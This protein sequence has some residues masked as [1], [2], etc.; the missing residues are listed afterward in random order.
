MGVFIK[1]ERDG[2]CS[3]DITCVNTVAWEYIAI[4]ESG[5]QA[6]SNSEARLADVL[7]RKYWSYTH[8]FCLVNG[9]KNLPER[10]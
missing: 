3:A 4:I 1:A 10:L 2:S 6:Q 9:I 7:L 5:C 8:E